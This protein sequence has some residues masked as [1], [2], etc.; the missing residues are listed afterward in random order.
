MAVTP[1]QGLI[2]TFISD[3]KRRKI[4][5]SHDV[6]LATANLL[7]RFVSASRWSHTSELIAEIRSLGG[8]LIRAQPREFACGNVV[9]R[10]LATIREVENQDRT[11][12]SGFESEVMGSMFNLLSSNKPDDPAEGPHRTKNRDTKADIIEGIQELIDE[13]DNHDDTIGAMSLDM[14]HE[15]EVLLTPT[16]ESKTVKDFLIRAAQKR[17]FSV[18]I[19]DSFPNGVDK[20]HGLAKEL[21]ALGIETVVIPDTL[22]LAVMSRV[23]KVV[24]GT[25][26]V[27]ANGGCISSAGVSLVCECAHEYRTPVL[28]VTGLYKLSPLYPFDIESLIEVGD[29][30]KVVAFNDSSLMNQ[31]EVMNPTYDYVAPE[32]IGIY[33]T[34]IGGYSPSFTYRVVLDHYSPEDTNLT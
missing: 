3:L 19:T 28:A 2:S 5:G 20:S 27:L 15:N 33:A 7:L 1:I 11:P 17:R 16:P 22:V 25:R 12:A 9:R 24:I 26:T 14:I 18:L 32:H 10:V 34:N 31:V 29:S 13:I 23:G 30:A 6:A 8:T 21:S 4:V